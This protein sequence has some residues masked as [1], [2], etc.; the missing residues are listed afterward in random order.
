MVSVS[1]GAVASGLAAGIAFV[2]LFLVFP[3][4]SGFRD[5]TSTIITLERTACFGTCPAY[6]VTLYGNGTVV[7][8]GESFVAVNGAQKS[9]VDPQAVKGLVDEFYNVGFF[10]LR[11]RYEKCN[12][13]AV[14]D[15]VYN[16]RRRYKDCLSLRL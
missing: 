2:V 3:I 11:D 9:Q 1:A 16:N 10:S 4:P 8:E 15:N 7:Y 13:P 5:S 12:R 14:A 6:H